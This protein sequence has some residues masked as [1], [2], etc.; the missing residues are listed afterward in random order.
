MLIVCIW[1]DFISVFQAANNV[2]IGYA[3]KR[4]PFMTIM[5]LFVLVISIGSVLIFYNC[6]YF[7]HHT[8]KC[9]IYLH[10]LRGLVYDWSILYRVVDSYTIVYLRIFNTDFRD[11]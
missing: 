9:V 1:R 11:S 7:C 3:Q 5:R 8:R 10:D 2:I 6:I 4:Q